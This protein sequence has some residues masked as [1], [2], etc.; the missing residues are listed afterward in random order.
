MGWGLLGGWVAGLGPTREREIES[1]EKGRE[2]KE[3][4]EE[5]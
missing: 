5:R 3:R 1:R 2:R 4:G